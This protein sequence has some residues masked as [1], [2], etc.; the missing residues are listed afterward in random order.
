MGTCWTFIAEGE[1]EEED[2]DVVDLNAMDVSEV[3]QV[4]LLLIDCAD[5]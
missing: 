3:I 4:P 1:E 5:G 2:I